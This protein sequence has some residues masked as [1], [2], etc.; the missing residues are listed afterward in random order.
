MTSRILFLC[1]GNYYRSR[2]AEELFNHRA[3]SEGLDWRATSRGLAEKGS[4]ENVGPMSRFALEALSAKTIVP[5][6]AARYPL[7]CSVV[8]FDQARLVIALKEAEH[9]PVIERRFPGAASRVTYWHVDD[10]GFAHPSIALAMIDDQVDQ[11][12]SM[13]RLL[14]AR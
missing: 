11:L 7:P 12:I 2:Y 1:T 14:A 4:P 13:L 9:R 3:K 6:G 5:E 10:I 8:D